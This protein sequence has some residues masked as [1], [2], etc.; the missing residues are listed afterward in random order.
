MRFSGRGKAAAGLWLAAALVTTAPAW[1][2]EDRASVELPAQSLAASLEALA[3][4]FHNQL[5]Y[6]ADLVKGLN[7]AA[8]KGEFT[9][10]EALGKLLQG[11]GLEAKPAGNG[12]FTIQKAPHAQVTVLD[13]ITV[14]ATRT[15][16]RAF[17]VPASVSTVTRDQIESSQAKDMGA[18]VNNLPGVTMEA[19]R[20]AGAIPTIRGYQGPDIILRVDDA[21][22]SLDSNVGVYTPMLVDPNFIRQVDVVRGPSSA[23]Y[24]G[25]GLGGVMS[26]R[27]IDADDILDPGKSIGGQ[28]KT[29]RRTVDGT[30]MTNLI[31]AARYSGF[32]ALAGG[33]FKEYTGERT[34]TG[35]EN[36]QHCMQRNGLFKLGWAPDEDNKL[37][38]SYMRFSDDGWGPTNPQ[39]APNA[40]NGYQY[41]QKHQD[42]LVAGY[43]FKNG[44]WLD[45][46]ISVFSTE[47]K[48]DDQKRQNSDAPFTT[49]AAANSTWDVLTQ[50]YNAQNSMSFDALA[51][52][53][54][55][56]YGMDGY[57]DSLTSTSAGGVNSVTP[58]GHMLAMGGFVQDEVALPYGWS[59]I[60]TFRYDNYNANASDGGYGENSNDQLSP[61]LA[62]K[63][64]V[65]PQ[66]GLFTSYGKAFRAP[67]LS[68]LYMNSTGGFRSFKAN[69]T[70]LPESSVNW[71]IGGTLSFD[72]LLMDKD[73]LRLK[74]NTYVESVKN[75]IVQKNAGTAA[76]P[77]QYQNIS[78][79]HR[80]G[81][82]AELSYRFG[83]W[84]TSLGAS[85]VRV[86]D[87]VT[88]ESLFAP[89]DKLVAG[90]SYCFDE[91]LSA[92]YNGR[93][94]A[95]QDYDSTA[96][97][98]RAGYA[99]HDIGVAYDR[100]WY[101][102]DVSATNLF[103]KAYVI[104]YS[105][106][107]QSY[108]YSE[109]RSVNMTLTARF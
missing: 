75:S 106:N 107:T 91:Y 87:A 15:P 33:T 74:V 8:L 103:D 60:P 10:E 78:K 3:G 97:R 16:N 77:Y 11:S 70:L 9:A 17:D 85:M 88:G 62:V 48:Y 71:E 86:S 49:S 95:S 36:V 26:V 100:D 55:L 57:R 18:V 109:G 4:S 84:S 32:S 66:L 108:S 54:R 80:R 23:T 47:L 2:A 35:G 12:A 63:W 81:T 61:K 58:D 68:E 19:S 51:L 40:Q 59:L 92:R 43:Q 89:P 64:Q 90:L 13:T 76:D 30:L 79:A 93:F 21:R 72:D 1:A 98:R 42:D 27:T 45:G 24:G 102:V 38:V 39:S 5:L 28:A 96:A 99:V 7:G 41:Q 37:T 31:S 25:G 73:A 52:G 22:H 104:Y 69:P 65:L 82:E 101:R 46:K 56:T 14:T 94:L 29:E 20:L 53:H 6:S 34:G 67:T 105:S 44:P 83:D 50:G